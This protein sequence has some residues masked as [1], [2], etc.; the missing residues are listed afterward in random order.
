[1]T[2]SEAL[3]LQLVGNKDRDGW[4]GLFH[5]DGFVEDPVEAG[6]Y[7]GTRNIETFWLFPIAFTVLVTSKTYSV[8]KAATVPTTVNSEQ[9]LVDKNARLAVLG[10]VAGGLGAAPALG[11]QA[12]WGS[13]PTLF[14]ASAVYLVGMVAALRL[15]RVMIDDPDEPDD[16]MEL[17]SAGVRLAS[18]VMSVL[19]GITGFVFWLMVFAYGNN[20]IDTCLQEAA[21]NRSRCAQG[22]RSPPL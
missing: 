3:L 12:I 21:R 13:T 9:E 6:Q 4:V 11:L 16:V 22:D 17:R 20:D 10:T 8:A 1:M 14:Y 2:T 5:S 18:T 7:H 19:R 15:P